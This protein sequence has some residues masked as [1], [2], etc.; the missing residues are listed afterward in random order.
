VFKLTHSLI[1]FS[2]LEVRSVKVHGDQGR[3]E[4]RITAPLSISGGQAE[5]SKRQESQT[6]SLRRRDQKSWEPLL[7]QDTIYMPQDTAARLLAHQLALLA[8][9][10]STNLRQKSQLSQMLN[11]I[12]TQ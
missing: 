1:V 2:R 5:L 3:A 4:V 10:E 8:D 12:R 9:S 6:W 11:R 7:P